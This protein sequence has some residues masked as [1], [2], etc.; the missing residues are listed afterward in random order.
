MK[1]FIKNN[2]GFTLVELVIATAILGIISLTVMG[3]MSTGTNMFT[4]IQKRTM[5]MFKSQSTSIQLKSYLQNCNGY[6]I[7]N[8]A[9]NENI[10]L[11]DKENLYEIIYSPSEKLVALYQIPGSE[12]DTSGNVSDDFFNSRS[13]SYEIVAPLSYNVSGIKYKVYTDDNGYATAVKFDITVIRLGQ[14]YTR[15]QT[16]ALRSKVK[17]IDANNVTDDIAAEIGKFFANS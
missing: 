7:Y 16:V 14:E 6:I 10:I 4:A 8:S 2:K 13:D 3:L 9:D 15:S 17:C 11:T 12:I 1:K 5:T